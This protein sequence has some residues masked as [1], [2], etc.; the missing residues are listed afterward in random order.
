MPFTVKYKTGPAGWVEGDTFDT[1]DEVLEYCAE[2]TTL[3]DSSATPE[4]VR[5]WAD[6]PDDGSGISLRGW[7]GDEQEPIVYG[8]NRGEG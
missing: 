4:Q 1:I 8:I 2:D 3:R 5:A 6:E 7:Y